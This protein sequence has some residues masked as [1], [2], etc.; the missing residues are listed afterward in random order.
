[1]HLRSKQNVKEFKS[2]DGKFG[3][4]VAKKQQKTKGR[5]RTKDVFTA[6]QV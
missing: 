3:F 1:M 4:D 6:L 5:E 2:A